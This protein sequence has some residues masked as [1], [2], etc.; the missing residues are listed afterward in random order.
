VFNSS[1]LGNPDI[2]T[3]DLES[4]RETVLAAT[5]LSE[6]H[7]AISADRSTVAY[8][9]IENQRDSIHVVVRGGQ[10]RQLCDDC[11][12]PW[13]LSSDGKHMLY[14]SIDQRH[15][16][17]IDVGSGTRTA[18]LSHPTYAILRATFSPDNR[19]IAFTAIGQAVNPLNFIAPFAE[20]GPLA[21]RGWIALSDGTQFEEV[22]RWSP[23]GNLM[24]LVSQR[25]GFECLWGLRLDP[26]TKRPVGAL[27]PV[28]HLHSARR[29]LGNVI[30]M[31]KEFGVSND[32]LVFPLVERTGNIWMLER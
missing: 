32:R 1:R 23:D 20:S 16:G 11:F 7:A 14:W 4:G 9:V 26:A 8:Q 13:D 2:W 29:S 24:Y 18:L 25:D 3:K 19:W 10:P 22:A 17:L 28:H 31:F 30:V 15:V 12:L 21:E 6:W 27:F 5:P